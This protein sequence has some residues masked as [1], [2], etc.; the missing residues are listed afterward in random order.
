MSARTVLLAA[1]DEITRVGWGI[2]GFFD[3]LSVLAAIRDS[4]GVVWADGEDAILTVH[5]YLRHHPELAGGR[6]VVDLHDWNRYGCPDQA[7]AVAVLRGAA[8]MAGVR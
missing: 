8:E 6:E 4:A 5:A 1:V 3:G 2:G 7:T